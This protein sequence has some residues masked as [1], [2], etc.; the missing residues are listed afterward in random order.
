MRI[1]SF[2]Q[3]SE[4]KQEAEELAVM[5]SARFSHKWEAP[6]ANLAVYSTEKGQVEAEIL[7]K[8]QNSRKR[9]TLDL[10]LFDETI[11]HASGAEEEEEGENGFWA[12]AAAAAVVVADGDGVGDR[13]GLMKGGA[14]DG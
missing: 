9:F 4:L 13:T 2:I 6:G 3:V 7:A 10:N 12:D 5:I 8:V 1:L 11:P 14:D